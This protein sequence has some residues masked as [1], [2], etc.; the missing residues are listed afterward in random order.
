MFRHTDGMKRI[1]WKVTSV[2]VIKVVHI[3]M[4]KCHKYTTAYNGTTPSWTN[5]FTRHRDTETPKALTLLMTFFVL[6]LPCSCCNTS[7]RNTT[8]EYAGDDASQW[9]RDWMS[10]W[11]KGKRDII[12]WVVSAARIKNNAYHL[13]LTA[14]S[15]LQKAGV[16][17]SG[18]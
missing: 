14:T 7:L 6:P 1:L 11:I 3:N 9:S 18:C 5:H 12:F 15:G 4:I 17:H 2:F 13:K 16:Q 8:L 10:Y